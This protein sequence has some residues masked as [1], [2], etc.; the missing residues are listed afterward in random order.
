MKYLKKIVGE[1]N[2]KIKEQ[3]EKNDKDKNNGN[4]EESKL[5]FELDI[6]LDDEDGISN[7]TERLDNLNKR[8]NELIRMK[9]KKKEFDFKENKDKESLFLDLK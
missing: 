6:D 3:N 1:T 2:Q 5:P 7:F 9:F 8:N 4:N